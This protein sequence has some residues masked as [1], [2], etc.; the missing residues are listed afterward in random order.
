MRRRLRE[1]RGKKASVIIVIV[2]EEQN[3]KGM[4]SKTDTGVRQSASAPRGAGLWRFGNW[5]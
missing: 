3:E 5:R 2:L 4:K 1:H